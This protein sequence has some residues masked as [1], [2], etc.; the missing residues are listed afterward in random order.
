M[1]RFAAYDPPEYHNWTADPAEVQ[2][3]R[4]RVSA[5]PEREAV[6]R[7]LSQDQLLDM[8]AGLLRNRLHDVALKRWVKNGVISKAWLGV[9]EEAATIGPVHALR[10]S[11]PDH[12]VVAPMIRNSGACHEMGMPV[13][14]ILRSYLGTADSPSL[15]RDLHVGELAVGVL[16]P[17]SHV[18]DVVPVI[19][20]IA[21]SFKQRGQDRVGM[22]WTGDGSTK[23]AAFHEGVNFAGVHQLP[24][25]FIIQNNQVALGTRLSQHAA[26]SFADWPMMY[27]LAGGVFDGNHVLDAYAAARL[28]ADRARAGEGPSLL[29]AETFRMSGHAT[30]DEREAREL[31]DAG[32]FASWGRRDPVGLYEAWLMENGIGADVLERIEARVT[33]EIDQAAEEALRSRESAM[34]VP[35]SAVTGVYA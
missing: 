9:G 1:K 33:A 8:Y 32:L 7:A 26:G 24:V 12:D 35:E 3:Y 20:G 15:G 6:I 19:S 2:R 21:L 23:T 29:V 5:D 34:P 13:T 28:A 11:G 14:D 10:R 31:F 30:H 18:G 16:P 25:V 27:G 4:E 22:T 17:I